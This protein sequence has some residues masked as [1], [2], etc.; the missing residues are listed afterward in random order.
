[1]VRLKGRLA[2][3]AL[4]GAISS[5]PIVAQDAR[6]DVDSAHSTARLVLSSSKKPASQVNVGV[7]RVSGI[8][9]GTADDSD[10]SAFDLTIYPADSRDPRSEES[11]PDHTVITFRSTVVRPVD[12]TTVQATGDL[13]VTYLE[14]VVTYGPMESYSGPVYGPPIFHS[15]KR[16][17]TFQFRLHRTEASGEN[18]RRAEWSA[19]DVIRGATFPGLLRAVEVTKWPVLVEDERCAVPSG[20]EEDYSGPSCTG[21][22]VSVTP[23]TDVHCQMPTPINEESYSG[24]VC[25]GIPLLTYPSDTDQGPATRGQ[26]VANE[27]TIDLDL[28]LTSP[29]TAVSRLVEQSNEHDSKR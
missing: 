2:I 4:L 22:L 28:R 15:Q 27:V 20:S 8:A 18:A 12:D 3:T 11:T 21:T 24:E 10:P 13:T 23:R 29:N 7:A 19:S 14:R 17:V 6:W 26:L 25:T 1:M 5:I 16:E 9:I